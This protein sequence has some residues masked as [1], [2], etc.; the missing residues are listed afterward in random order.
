MK[1]RQQVVSLGVLLV[2]LGLMGLY[3]VTRKPRFDTIYT[4]DVVQ[5]IVTGMCFGVALGML[6]MFFRGR[7]SN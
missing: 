6:G 7:R 1:N 4:V 2:S 3:N 5:L